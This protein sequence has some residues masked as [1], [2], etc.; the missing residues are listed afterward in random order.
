MTTQIIRPD[1][2]TGLETYIRSAHPGTNYYGNV[3]ISAGSGSAGVYIFRTLMKLDLSKIPGNAVITS[4]VLS[5]YFHYNITSS[6]NA[7]DFKVYRFTQ[8]WVDT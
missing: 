1:D 2:T 7:N 3:D 4:A 6:T 8:A 5:L